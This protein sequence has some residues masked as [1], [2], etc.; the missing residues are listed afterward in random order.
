M[1]FDDMYWIKVA[2]AEYKVFV[3]MVMNIHFPQQ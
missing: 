1:N 3:V 2:W